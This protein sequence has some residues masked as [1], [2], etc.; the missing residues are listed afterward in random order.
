MIEGLEPRR[1]FAVNVAVNGGVLTVTGDDADNF[2]QVHLKDEDTLVVRS[3]TAVAAEEETTTADSATEETVATAAAKMGPRIGFELED[4]ATE[5]F[6]ISDLGITSIAIDV[7]GG[8]DR[9]GVG[10]QIELAA[11]ID[12]GAGDDHLSGG[13]GADTISGDDGNDHIRGG[14][15][16][17]TLNG[18]GGNDSIGAV[19]QETDVIDGGDQTTDADGS[20]GDMAIIDAADGATPDTV[21]NVELTR[22]GGIGF[23]PGVGGRGDGP[24]FGG[25]RGHRPGGGGHG[26]GEGEQLPPPTDDGAT[27]DGTIGGT[28]TDPAAPV[29]AGTGTG[30][31]TAPPAEGTLPRPPADDEGRPRG[32]RPGGPRGD[33]PMGHRPPPPIST[34]DATGD[35]NTDESDLTSTVA[36]ISSILT[37]AAGSAPVRFVN[38]Q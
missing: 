16:A 20:S 33:G 23:G 15:G 8:N 13:A 2:V 21:T 31:E 27:R 30:D 11:T 24:G 4:S 9:A 7:A 25:R 37:T 1:L 19:D 22:A 5:E 6:D 35:G 26:P 28:I 10:P 3:A 36:P 29:E 32:R 17:D 18:N 38:R 14:K 34:D 12:G